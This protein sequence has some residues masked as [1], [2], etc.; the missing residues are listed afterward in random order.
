MLIRPYAASDFAAV[1]ALWDVTGITVAYNDP[2][3]DIPRMLA[4]PNCQLYVGTE[5]ER[6]I[7]S[8]M[9]GHEGH[10]GWLYKLAV[11]PEFQGKGLGRALVRQAE[12]WLVARGVPKVNLMIRDT[13]LNVRD[14]YQRLGYAV[15]ARTVMERWLN[16]PDAVDMD[17]ADLDVVTTYMEMTERPTRPTVPCPA[18]Q[19]AVLRLERPSNAFYRYLYAQVGELW[20]WS[21]RRRMSDEALQAA[22]TAEGIEIYVLYA[23]GEPAGYVELDR[24]EKPDIRIAYFGL[25]PHFIGRGLGRYLLNW[26]VDL[27]WSYGPQRLLVSTWSFDHPRA[28]ANYQRAGFKPCQ[29]ARGKLRDPRL[30]GW[31]PADV[32]P[33]LAPPAATP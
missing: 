27:A 29:Q 4:T 13:N 25:A 3:K 21:D 11:I 26:A 12:R 32:Q 10:R 17:A 18:G 15:A 1:T 8:I 24:R 33:R 16:T 22:I 23:G 20:M 9:V 2:A 31:I 14:F 6:I 5:G 30:E 28:F 7:A 19:Y